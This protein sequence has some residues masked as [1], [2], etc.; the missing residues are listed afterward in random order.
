MKNTYIVK[1]AVFIILAAAIYC[2][3]FFW[4]FVSY[5]QPEQIEIWLADAG[6][7]AP[8]LYMVVMAMAVVISP[9]PSLPLDIAAGAFFGPLLGTVYSVAGALAGAVISFMI[10]RFLGRELM[11]RFLGGHVNFCEGCSDMILTKI[12]L[13]SRLLPVISFDVVSYGAGLTKMSLKKFS[14]A[15]FLGMIPL[16]FIYNYSGSVLVFGKGLTFVLGVLMVAL[17]FIMPK[18][19]ERKGFLKKMNHGHSPW[20]TDK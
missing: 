5:F 17:F 4:D 7:L 1:G 6:N 18:W 2:L 9:V 20:K 14:L 16:T 12:V 19:L 15:T 13:L 11:E 3:Q 10:A 8:L